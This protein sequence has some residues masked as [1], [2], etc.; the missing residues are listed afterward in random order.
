MEDIYRFELD[1]DMFEKL[2]SGKKTAQLAINE[3]KRKVYA[4]GNQITFVKKQEGLE[5]EAEIKNASIE[6]LLYFADVVEAVGTLGK[7]ACGFKNSA[8]IEKASDIFLSNAS[9]EAIE[10]NGIVAIVFKV[11]E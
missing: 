5:G 3:P 4:V 9:F 10:K 1:S 8:T 6:N 11:I 2:L 7:E